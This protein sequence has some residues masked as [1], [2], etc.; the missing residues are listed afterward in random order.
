M[1]VTQELINRFF[2]NECTSLEVE[3]IALYFSEHAEEL[4]KYLTKEEWD[5]INVK[6]E[7]NTETSKKLYKA[8]KSSIFGRPQAGVITIIQKKKYWIDAAS[9]ILVAGLSFITQT[10]LFRNEDIAATSTRNNQSSN[11]RQ[12]KNEFPEWRIEINTNSS[13]KEIE[14]P[15]GSTAKLYKNSSI[16]FPETFPNNKREVKLKGDAFF[17]VAKN[18]EKPFTVYSGCLS[19]TA[20]GTSFRVTLD[21]EETK[22]I[23]V[24]LYTGKVVIRAIEKLKNWGKDILLNPGEQMLYNREAGT[25]AVVT[26]FHDINSQLPRLKSNTIQAQSQEIKFG[27]TSLPEVMKDLS[28]FFNVKIDFTA[29]HIV[30][31]NF[32]G[33]I[34]RMDDIAAVLK[35]IAL[36]N[37]LESKKTTEGFTIVKP[38]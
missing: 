11:A 32:S 17:E 21:T 12:A 24:K 22:N 38:N 16:S 25:M 3:A 5:S 27:N 13:P 36:M 29:E 4:D 6:E 1:Q 15:D 8:V 19:T 37:G 2:A 35:V 28:L 34:N 30:K 31:M 26:N 23:Q 7:L 18:K 10:H 14:L 9:L 33:T 20:L